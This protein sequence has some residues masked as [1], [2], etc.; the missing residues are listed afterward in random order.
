MSVPYGEQLTLEVKKVDI[1]LLE[2]YGLFVLGLTEAEQEEINRLQN[3]LKRTGAKDGFR[4]A[5]KVLSRLIA[6]EDLRHPPFLE[7]VRTY[8]GENIMATNSPFNRALARGLGF[9]ALHQR[10]VVGGSVIQIGNTGYQA[11]LEPIYDRYDY[12]DAEI[13]SLKGKNSHLA[14]APVP[15]LRAV[16]TPIPFSQA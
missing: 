3:H 7:G 4:V 9:G 15:A 11:T 1:P 6:G 16:I 10:D 14:V 2:D 13:R 5:R 8:D 12:T